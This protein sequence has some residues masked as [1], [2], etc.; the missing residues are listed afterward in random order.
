[1][2]ARPGGW[3]ERRRWPRPGRCRTTAPRRYLRRRRWR[4][5]WCVCWA[6]ARGAGARGGVRPRLRQDKGGRRELR[7]QRRSR[8]VDGY[9]QRR[10]DRAEAS[11]VRLPEQLRQRRLCRGPGR[12][13]WGC[14]PRLRGTAATCRPRCRCGRSCLEEAGA[15]C[16]GSR[17]GRG[18]RSR[19][20]SSGCS[21]GSCP[22]WGRAAAAAWGRAAAAAWGD[23][24]AAA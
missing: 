24:A 21:S 4:L 13:R 15:A 10:D 12:R 8:V 5:H 14:G 2:T 1:L 11:C 3:W 18:R 19:G 22:A 16:G 7:R 17:A 20:C 6:E 23:A 9:R